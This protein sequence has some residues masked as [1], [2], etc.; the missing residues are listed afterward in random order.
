MTDKQFAKLKD[1]I[2]DK[3]EELEKLQAKYH[4]E[5]GQDFVRPLRLA[6]RK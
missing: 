6:P 4:A 2:E 1:Q 3:M 5:T